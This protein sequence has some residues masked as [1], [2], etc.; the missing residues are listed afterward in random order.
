MLEVRTD[1]KENVGCKRCIFYCGNLHCVNV[2][3]LAKMMLHYTMRTTPVA[4]F[5]ENSS[6]EYNPGPEGRLGAYYTE[7]SS[8]NGKGSCEC[9]GSLRYRSYGKHLHFANPN[10]AINKRNASM[11]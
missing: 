5:A 4:T 3:D 1:N 7:A 8:P 9:D 10:L 11:C 2:N 6:N